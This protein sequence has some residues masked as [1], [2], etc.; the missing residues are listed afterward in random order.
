MRS[1]C[2]FEASSPAWLRH[3]FSRPITLGTSDVFHAMGDE[4]GSECC[5][6]CASQ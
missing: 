4:R 6:Y 1:K 2:N 5:A 3:L